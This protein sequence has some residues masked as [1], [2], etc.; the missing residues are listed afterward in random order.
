ME[1][2]AYAF[3]RQTWAL[4]CKNLLIIVV[5]HWFST[6][7]RAVV[8]P[9]AF[10]G[11][12]VNIKSLIYP[13]NGFGIGSPLPVS[14]L[15]DVLPQSQK[16]V[17]VQPPN[18]GDDVAQVID[19]VTRPLQNQYQIVLLTNESDLLTTCRE[20]LVGETD[21]FAAVVFN[22]SPLTTGKKG[23]WDYTIRSNSN[24]AGHKFQ[25]SQHTNDQESIYLPLQVAVDN[26]IMNRTIIPNEYM[27]TTIS[28]ADED[29]LVRR[30]YQKL[31]ITIYGVVFFISFSS[32]IYHLVGMMT[33]ER[34]SGM[35]QL[36]DAMGGSPAVRICSYIL[37]FNII[38]A[39]SWIAFGIC[40][41]FFSTM[42]L[43]YTSLGNSFFLRF[44][45][46]VIDTLIY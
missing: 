35:A 16:L 42:S 25:V 6:I 26:C 36:I 41:L 18:T 32:Q 8:L 44:V 14:S 11:F 33:S 19:A 10:M 1:L 17:L 5:R 34:A 45:Y 37:S 21:C 7:F 28:Q 43:T 3:Y 23:I 22:D 46:H 9:V 12:L 40:K 38:Y 29:D 39:P 4:T 15:D 2:Q 31:I 24:S 20:N 13:N 27:F 30:E